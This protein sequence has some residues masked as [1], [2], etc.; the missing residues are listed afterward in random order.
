MKTIVI[1]QDAAGYPERLR[2]LQDAFPHVVAVCPPDRQFDHATPINI[3]LD[4]LPADTEI[5]FERRCWFRA[6]A[7]GL[8]AVQQLNLDAD[9]YWFIESDC[10]ASQDRWK[11]LFAT[12]NENPADFVG[13]PFRAK[14]DTPGNHWWPHPHTPEWATHFVIPACA[15]YSRRAVHELTRTAVETRECFC[16]HAIASTIIRAGF[17]HVS[18]NVPITHWNQQTYRTTAGT[19]IPNPRFLQ[20]PVKSDTYGP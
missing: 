3:P 19:A 4:W 7:L 5:P 12:H 11:S 16:E 1:L 13:N 18:V 20:H 8:A 15:R 6:H 9:A 17:T 2:A 14:G 10:V